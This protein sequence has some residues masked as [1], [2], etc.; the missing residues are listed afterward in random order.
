MASFLRQAVSLWKASFHLVVV[1]AP[2]YLVQSSLLSLVPK[3][4]PA[5][6]PTLDAEVEKAKER[7]TDFSMRLPNNADTLFCGPIAKELAA[8]YRADAESK[9]DAAC[10]ASEMAKWESAVEDPQF[11]QHRR[12]HKEV[13]ELLD[14]MFSR[15][16]HCQRQGIL[17]DAATF[18]NCVASKR[19]EDATKFSKQAKVEPDKAAKKAK[20]R[21]KEA[22]DEAK[23]AED[24]A[25]KAEEKAQKAKERAIEEAIKAIAAMIFTSSIIGLFL[26]F[27]FGLSSRFRIKLFRLCGLLSEQEAEFAM[28][29]ENTSM[30]P[31]VL[32]NFRGCRKSKVC[33]NYHSNQIL[34]GRRCVY[35]AE[36]HQKPELLTGSAFDIRG[37]AGLLKVAYPTVIGIAM[38]AIP[39]VR[40]HRICAQTV[41]ISTAMLVGSYFPAHAKQGVVIFDD[42]TSRTLYR[43]TASAKKGAADDNSQ[44][45][46]YTNIPG[47]VGAAYNGKTYGSGDWIQVVVSSNE[48]VRLLQRD[49]IETK[50]GYESFPTASAK[51][52]QEAIKDYIKEKLRESKKTGT[53]SKSNLKASEKDFPPPTVD[54]IER[55]VERYGEWWGRSIRFWILPFKGNDAGFYKRMRST[56]LRADD[57]GKLA[58]ELD[59]SSS[60]GPAP[61][62]GSPPIDVSEFNEAFAFIEGKGLLEDAMRGLY[63]SNRDVDV[64]HFPRRLL[65]S[66]M[67]SLVASEPIAVFKTKARVKLAELEV[68]KHPVPLLFDDWELSRAL[69]SPLGRVLQEKRGD[70]GSWQQR[71]RKLLI[72]LLSE[73]SEGS[74]KP[75]QIEQEGTKGTQNR[76]EQLYREEKTLFFV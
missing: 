29:V 39:F 43:A 73:K 59:L 5:P 65:H 33:T 24:E 17:A 53:R 7:W 34:I 63:R 14:G 38:T 52:L 19:L 70:K 1:S 69:L 28:I 37:P 49:S 3:A 67:Y 35:I 30:E 74:N 58:A 4:L 2:L 10:W 36:N 46:E 47:V 40:R 21:A 32:T 57:I 51:E 56:K 26:G 23:K 71:T 20:E 6:N 64:Q 55:A 44:L 27:V 25:K 72:E 62:I 13:Q 18:W 45:A 42:I 54:E 60:S 31:A 68:G 41:I 66:V 48:G 12:T 50:Y 15:I 76:D 9:R 16:L 11:Q 75:H 61:L 22:E 8:A